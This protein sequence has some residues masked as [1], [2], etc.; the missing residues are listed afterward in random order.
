MAADAI[1]ASIT[2]YL[3]AVR[4]YLANLGTTMESQVRSS[5]LTV[6]LS[7]PSEYR[8]PIYYPLSSSFPSRLTVCRAFSAHPSQNPLRRELCHSDSCPVTTPHVLE[9][10]HRPLSGSVELSRCLPQQDYILAVT[11]C[12][13]LDLVPKSITWSYQYALAQTMR[14]SLALDLVL[15]KLTGT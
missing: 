10:R 13:V 15:L 2:T 6:F 3:P 4:Y 12:L 8:Q 1:N 5:V 7:T 11:V 14:M 9:T